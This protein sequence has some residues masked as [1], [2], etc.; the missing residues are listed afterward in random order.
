MS[1]NKLSVLLV[2]DNQEIANQIVT[3]LEQKGV[4][5]DYAASGKVALNLIQNNVFDLVI[6]DLML[7]DA[8]G[9]DL[10]GQL[11]NHAKHHL[12]V[13]MLT[14]RDSLND[15]L[16]GFEKGADDYLT[17][18]FALEEVY[19]R[20][21]ALSRRVKLHQE[22]ITS[23]GELTLDTGQKTVQRQGQAISL[24]QTDFTILEILVMAY[25]NAV[26]KRELVQKVWGDD[27][28]ET[29]AVRSHIY[30]LRNGVDKPFEQ[31]MIKTV[32]GIGFKLVINE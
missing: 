15:K 6:L 17:K 13:L 2:E 29:D 23:V 26:S 24:S 9:Y 1:T 11:K 20:C 14:A 27:A 4:L 31:A 18:P 30:T 5:V 10:C 8:D 3:Y 16:Q 19:M 25:P 12:P 28:P 7:P 22:K 21:L 32:H